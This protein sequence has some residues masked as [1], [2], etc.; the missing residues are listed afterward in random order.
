LAERPVFIDSGVFLGMHDRDA[1]MRARCL[2]FFRQHHGAPFVHMNYEQIGLC[3]AYVWRQTRRVQDVYYPFM[4]V[5]HTDM[6]L[7]RAGYDMED[8][9]L[10]C[11][12]P[13]L[14]GLRPEQ[15]LL[16]AQVLRLDAKLFTRDDALHRLNCLR[17]RLFEPSF[18]LASFPAGLEALYRASLDFTYDHAD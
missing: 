10:A 17:E 15:S 14:V 8:V 7:R 1:E 16:V 9:V 3:D 6:P 12:H 4:D 18:A 2:T 13:E 5:L 11:R